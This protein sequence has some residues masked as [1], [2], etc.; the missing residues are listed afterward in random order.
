MPSAYKWSP[1]P[2]GTLGHSV[3]PETIRGNE[4]R[5][6]L[7][8]LKTAFKRPRANGGNRL[9]Q[10]HDFARR[11]DEYQALDD[12]TKGQVDQEMS[13]G[14]NAFLEQ[15]GVAIMADRQ[16]YYPNQFGDNCLPLVKAR[17]PYGSRFSTEF[18]GMR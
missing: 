17:N 3:N 13:V 4:H 15:E 9:K 2:A 16:R 11:Y 18:A 1:H 14:D 6:S 10:R 12:E 7:T 5:A 8:P